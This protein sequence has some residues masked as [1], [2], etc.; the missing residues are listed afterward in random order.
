MTLR[1][2][3]EGTAA[4][5]DG[6]Q[7]DQGATGFSWSRAGRPFA[8]LSAD[9]AEAEFALDGPVAAAATRTP[10]VSPSSRGAGW[11]TFRPAVL[12]DHA[13]DRAAAWFASAHRQLAR[14]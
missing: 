9:G 14:G 12:D 8:V 13:A 1:E 7:V 4:E 3:L 6:V 11:V 2:L 10:G 5:L